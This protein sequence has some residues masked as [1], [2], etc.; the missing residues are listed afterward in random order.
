MIVL[1]SSFEKH[2]SNLRKVLQ[3]FKENNLKLKPKKCSFFQT[4]VL[5][6]GK[7][8]NEHGV[9]INPDSKET[10]LKWPIPKK[11]RDVQSFLG[12]ANYHR[13]HIKDYAK[14]A[15]PLYD[16]TK[17]KGPFSWTEKQQDAFKVIQQALI[18]SATLA[19]PYPYQPFILD[20]D[21]SND[22][23]GAELIQV[24][25]G[26]EYVI[27][28]ASKVL[29]PAQKKYC[30]TRKELL[31]VVTF[32]KQ[33]RN[34][35][36]GNQFTIRTDHNSL[37]WLLRFKTIEGQ[38]A[39]WLEALSEYDM[40]I[41]H[42]S[43]KNHGNADGLSRRPD[44]LPSCDCYYAGADVRSLPCGGCDYCSRAQRSW[45]KFED[46][47]D[48]VVPLAVRS[49]TDQVQIQDESATQEINNW[50][51]INSVD[52]TI[53]EQRKDPDLKRIIH[54]LENS[55]E[56]PEHELYLCSPAVKHWWNCRSQ[57]TF[58]KRMLCYRWLDPME[59]KLLLLV[60]VSMREEILQN[61]HDTKSAGHFGQNKT[62]NRVK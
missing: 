46:D 49:L 41:Q 47:V 15:V 22:T 28:Y 34:Y 8:V 4:E 36:L 3:R 2:L 58:V 19:Y 18:N 33:F 54:W 17:K 62:V 38:L 45:G 55:L 29:T 23:I 57:L 48:D 39:R 51:G 9:S 44:D 20:T 12:F 11:K 37:T 52:R 31:A 27:S 7:L 6:L 25:E 10:I 13:E 14:L 53:T 60:P 26:K 30:T 56:P 43:G 50:A 5:F 1:G 40:V 61:C 21:A 35:L 24:H 59:P 16:V 42:R 32:T